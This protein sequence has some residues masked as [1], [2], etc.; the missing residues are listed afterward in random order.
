MI[1]VLQRLSS[2]DLRALGEAIRSGRLYPPF[3]PMSV[4]RYSASTDAV[5][6]ASELQR[7]ADEGGRTEFLAFVL[8]VLADD[9]ASRS[10]PE[11]L[12]DLVWSG[13][14]APGT[15]SR[16]TPVVVRELFSTATQFVHVAG[17]AVYQGREVFRELAKRMEEL[18]ALKVQMFLDVHRAHG[19]TAKDSEILSEF[20]RR[21]KTREW[22]G[23]RMPDIYYDPR[24][25]DM[26]QSKKSSL[27]AKCIV[28]DR[29]C[30]FVSSANFT[31]AA[32]IRNIEVGALIR[33]AH[34]A[35]TLARHFEALADA[36]ILQPVPGI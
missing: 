18:P 31:E 9:R 6:V 21:F 29:A 19:D 17:Y 34:F 1:S 5:A 35:D 16:D 26:D 14:E 7:L 36:G 4:Q 3:T 23:N 24:A 28:I 22:P 13:P 8:E 25:L 32:Q 2:P 12:I 10:E 30:A 20:A 11:D 33:S 27:H 15:A